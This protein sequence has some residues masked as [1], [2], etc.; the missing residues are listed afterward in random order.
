M[1]TEVV[2]GAAGLLFAVTT[3]A[4]N[5]GTLVAVE[6]RGGRLPPVVAVLLLA[7]AVGCGPLLVGG[8]VSSTI[9]GG[10]VDFAG[11]RHDLAL[12]TT[13]GVTVSVVVL[14]AFRGLP[15]SLFIAL[16]GSIAGTG[17][18]LGLEVSWATV[19]GVVAAGAVAPLVAGL[20]AVGMVRAER[21]VQP[22]TTPAGRLRRSGVRQV[23]GFVL[24]A[25]A[26]GSNG[27]QIMIAVLA[28]TLP[29]VQSSD[30]P[31]LAGCGVV[32]ACFTV[33]ALVGVWRLAGSL[34]TGVIS[35]R[36]HQATKAEVAAAVSV[37]G[38]TAAGLPVSV[39]QVT[40]AGLLGCG[41]AE[42]L[43]RVRW[44]HASRIVAAWMFT[45]PLALA[46]AA[47]VSLVA[48]AFGG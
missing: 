13:V 45:L 33:G 35:L 27:G 42:G 47:V 22:R 12:L 48:R 37:A 31:G 17:L 44:Q 23:A 19:V 29:S 5:G 36:P 32:A 15:S 8:A 3:G 7:A 21:Y 34:G 18:G 43:R 14:L 40:A 6:L 10:L 38:S 28:L 11:P 16:I 20:L 9:S 46:G 30:T 1:T 4:N 39:T 41:V 24:L 25:L 26:Y 2:L